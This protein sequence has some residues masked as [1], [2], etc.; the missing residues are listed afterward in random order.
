MKLPRFNPKAGTALA[1]FNLGQSR[2]IDLVWQQVGWCVGRG[3]KMKDMYAIV[4]AK[5]EKF[6]I[7]FGQ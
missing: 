2:L 5:R 3:H 7:D 1:V 4:R 6:I